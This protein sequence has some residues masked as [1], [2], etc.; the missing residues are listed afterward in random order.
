[1]ASM[2][3]VVMLAAT[4]VASA[5]VVAGPSRKDIRVERKELR[6]DRKELREDKKELREDKKELREDR[7][8][9]REARRKELREKWGDVVKQPDA[10]A[11]LTVHA[12]RVARL[13][14]AR[15][16]AETDGK[17]ELVTRID[18][19]VEKENAR[20]QRVMDRLKE[21]GSGGAP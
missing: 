2:L 12:R 7:K 14:Q 18:K 13:A 1:M 3:V 8:A 16:V 20:H 4:T 17:K 6:Q 19:L 15:K 5:D 11:E 9:K 21:K 10:R